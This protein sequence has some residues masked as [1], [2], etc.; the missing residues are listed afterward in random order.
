M[1]L[2]KGEKEL[3]EETAAIIGYAA[4]AVVRARRVMDGDGEARR[5]ARRELRKAA[6]DLWMLKLL[7]NFTDQDVVF[8]G[9]MDWADFNKWKDLGEERD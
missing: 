2:P 3:R 4:A 8:H 5:T 7:F 9:G 6:S 1:A